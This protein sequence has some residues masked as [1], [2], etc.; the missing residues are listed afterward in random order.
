MSREGAFV[1]GFTE[2]CERMEKQGILFLPAL[3]A[4][5]LVGGVGAAA[6]LAGA[7]KPKD[8]VQRKWYRAG[9]IPKTLGLTTA[10][11][12]GMAPG[13][14]GALGLGLRGLAGSEVASSAAGSR[15]P[16]LA[17]RPK[18]IART[19]LNRQPKQ[20]AGGF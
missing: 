13:A 6:G 10:L 14:S 12:G 9:E 18:S 11:A 2:E 20:I 7:G 5:L 17:W 1:Q 3:A 4:G 19:P 15:G 16:G 8:I